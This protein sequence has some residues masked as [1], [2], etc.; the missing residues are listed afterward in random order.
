[1]AVGVFD[2]R[3]GLLSELFQFKPSQGLN[4]TFLTPIRPYQGPPYGYRGMIGVFQGGKSNS[5]GG[6]FSELF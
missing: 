5:R 1:M 6:L 2:S 4:W 3:G